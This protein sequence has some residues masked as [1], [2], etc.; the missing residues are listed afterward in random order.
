MKNNAP[1]F[2]QSFDQKRKLYEVIRRVGSSLTEPQ[3][4]ATVNNLEMK[5]IKKLFGRSKKNLTED[6]SSGDSSPG[7]E[8]EI[9][10]PSDFKR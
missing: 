4:T 3:G 6:D 9:S 2:D 7:P 5:T 8:M 1:C 10:L